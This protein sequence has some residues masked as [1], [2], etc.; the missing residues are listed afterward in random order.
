MKQGEQH[1]GA[2]ADELLRML[3]A[4]HPTHRPSVAHRLEDWLRAKYDAIYKEGHED[5][6]LD[7]MTGNSHRIIRGPYGN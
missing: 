4:D 2:D 7:Q 3:G 1:P 6:R 5:G